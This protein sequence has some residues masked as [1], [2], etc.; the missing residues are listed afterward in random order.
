M[1]GYP[2]IE[3]FEDNAGAGNVLVESEP[4][5]AATQGQGF[6]GGPCTGMSLALGEELDGASELLNGD[7]RVV[8]SDCLIRLVVHG[9]AGDTTGVVHRVAAEIA[10]AVVDQSRL[11]GGKSFLPGPVR[12][13]IGTCECF[14]IESVSPAL[15]R[16]L[17]FPPVQYGVFVHCADGHCNR[18]RAETIF[19]GPADSLL[20]EPAWIWEQGWERQDC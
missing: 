10:V 4:E 1:L 14:S 19:G 18:L 20:G 17:T 11:Q 5:G 8:C 7:I 15:P 16:A 3:R 2:P 13:L 9:V 6:E 12:F